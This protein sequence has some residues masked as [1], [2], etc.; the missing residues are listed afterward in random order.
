MTNK[1]ASLPSIPVERED[2]LDPALAEILSRARGVQPWAVYVGGLIIV[3]LVGVVWTTIQTRLAELD[4]RAAKSELRHTATETNMA[5][6][7]QMLEDLR[8][9]VH[10]LRGDVKAGFEATRVQIGALSSQLTPSQR[11]RP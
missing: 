11:T 5:R 6:R 8:G 1:R 9:D 10:E 4:A 3:A 7:D 2:P